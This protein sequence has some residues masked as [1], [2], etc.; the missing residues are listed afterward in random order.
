MFAVDGGNM[1][2]KKAALS[3]RQVAVIVAIGAVVVLLSNL[4]GSSESTTATSETTTPST[5]AA[6]PVMKPTQRDTFVVPDVVGMTGYDADKAV[7][8]AAAYRVSTTF[9]DAV[10]IECTT[11]SPIMSP[12]VRTDPPAGT[13]LPASNETVVILFADLSAGATTCAPPAPVAPPPAVADIPDLDM[14]DPHLGCT[15]VD[16]YIRKDGVH[17]RGHWRC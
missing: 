16:A 3:A 9:E 1:A 8:A 5:S 4:F 6:F 7:E 11:A 15:Y 2:Q 13:V 17:V 10:H 12:I 14:P